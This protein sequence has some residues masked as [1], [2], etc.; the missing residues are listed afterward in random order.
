MRMESLSVS[1]LKH[2]Y[3]VYY[4]NEYENEIIDKERLEV[5]KEVIDNQYMPRNASKE[6]NAFKFKTPTDIIFAFMEPERKFIELL[7]EDVNV[8][9][10]SAWI[11]SRNN[12]FYNIGYSIREGNHPKQKTFNPDFNIKIDESGWENIV[13]VEIKADNDDS[14]ENKQKYKYANQHFLL[15][16][17]KLAR[18][19]IKQKYLFHFVSPMSYNPFFEYLRDGR[20]IAGQFKSVLELMLEQ[21][22][23]SEEDN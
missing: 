7:C 4:S 5:L 11:K 8:K 22:G 14:K 19:G 2:D 6:I 9:T 13:V 23:S 1:N 21:N 17:E 10:I 3:T 15:L 12:G 20:L 18:S 16:N